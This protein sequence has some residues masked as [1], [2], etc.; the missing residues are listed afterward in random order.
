MVGVIVCELSV[1]LNGDFGFL[2]FVGGQ[3]FQ[4]SNFQV[5]DVLL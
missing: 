2:V 1:Q 4:F 3:C 5:A